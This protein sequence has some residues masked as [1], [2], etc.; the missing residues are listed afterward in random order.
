MTG[1]THV[2]RG[3]RWR[4]RCA[5]ATAR[6]L[7]QALGALMHHSGGGRLTYEISGYSAVAARC[8]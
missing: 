3:S 8:L 5:V 1:K 4:H 7:Q 6:Q 2:V